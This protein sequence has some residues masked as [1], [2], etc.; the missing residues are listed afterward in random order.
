MSFWKLVKGI[1]FKQIASLG[2]FLLQH[3]IFMI[4][5]IKATSHTMKIVQ[6]EFPGIHGKDNKENAFRH[7][8][9]NCLIAFQCAKKEK[10]ITKVISWAKKITDW[11]EDFSPNIALARAMD[12]HNNYIGRELFQCHKNKTEKEIITALELKLTSAVQVY[13]IDEIEKHPVN[14]VFINN[15]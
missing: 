1:N 6:E 11:H 7:A 3:P 15:D 2:R 13:S 14:L 8:L 12:L 9:W 5:T 10:N 4:A